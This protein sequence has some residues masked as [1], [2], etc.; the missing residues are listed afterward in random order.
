MALT[1]R[2]VTEL[3][4]IATGLRAEDPRLAAMLS[5]FD[6]HRRRVQAT[7]LLTQAWAVLTAV[8]LVLAVLI[9]D[10]AP[11]V[12][13]AGQTAVLAPA[14]WALRRRSRRRG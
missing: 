3:R 4:D 10:L 11:L 12:L 6:P 1:E 5:D 8:L 9:R 14:R 2:E 7:R 13:A